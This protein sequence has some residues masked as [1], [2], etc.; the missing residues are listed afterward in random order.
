MH[1]VIVDPSRVV[2]S[3]LAAEL[4]AS[5]C[6][7]DCFSTSDLALQH[8]QNA[9]TV[10]VVLTSLELEPISG[11]EL[12]WSLRL[13]AGM[14][15][16]LHV[17]AMSSNTSERALT[18]ALDCGADDFLLKP[19][20]RDELKARLRAADRLMT[21][22][23]QLLEQSRTD[24]LTGLPN[25]RAFLEQMEERRRELDA[26]DQFSV[27]RCDIDDFKRINESYGRDIGDEV[28]KVV[29]DLA[30][31]EAPIV[32]RLG[33]V[34][35]AFAFPILDAT[36]AGHWCDVIRKSI[37]SHAFAS[38]LGSFKVTCSVG[39]SEWAAGESLAAALKQA[40][41]ALTQ[42]KAQG[43]NRVHVHAASALAPAA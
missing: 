41:I 26:T 31:E 8:V 7:V 20:G 22:Q 15:R 11:L 2:Q 33:G 28:V 24:M 13:V 18:E 16:P 40:E 38:Q 35:F 17:I 25:R 19:V 9:R 37:E 3:K 43:S 4:E 27:C 21:L 42:A 12:C 14:Q 23:R 30:R 10:D 36:Q 1:V 5:G 32:A 6:Y 29:A 39:V 34:E